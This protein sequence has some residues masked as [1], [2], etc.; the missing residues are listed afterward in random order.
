MQ[1]LLSSREA[2][3]PKTECNQLK[4]QKLLSERLKKLPLRVISAALYGSWARGLQTEDSDVD[5]LIVS[6]DIHPRRHKRGR[7]IALIKEALSIEYPLDILLLTQAECISNF[8]NHNPLFLDIA[9]EGII[10][11]DRDGLLKNLMHETRQYIKEKKIEKLKDGWRF[12]VR[13]REAVYLSQISN[14][15][16]ALAMITDGKRDFDIGVALIKEGYYDKAIYH[17]Q[18]AVE[19]SIKA[20]LISFGDFKKTHFVGGILIQRLKDIEIGEEW[21]EKLTKASKISNE[22]EPE[23]TW[24]RYPGIDQGR[25]WIP[26]EEYT[27][28]DALEIK[29]KA[30]IAVEIATDFVNWWFKER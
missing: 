9:W 5:L 3:K 4:I 19:K 10:L 21:K 6:D 22:L 27:K 2:M 12:P 24:S 17:F 26:Y 8:R 18:Q 23:V 29:E 15:D 14:R 13:Y 11:L 25:L 1:D 20:V 16:F 28:E 30:R 7:E